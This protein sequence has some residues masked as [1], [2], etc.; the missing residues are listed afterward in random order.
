VIDVDAGGTSEAVLALM[1]PL[2]T[3]LVGGPTPSAT[4]AGPPRPKM[5]KKVARGMIIGGSALFGITYGASTLGAAAVLDGSPN[6]DQF[7]WALSMAVPVV[8]P[9]RAAALPQSKGDR[10]ASIATG[11]MQAGGVALIVGGAVAASRHARADRWDRALGRPVPGSSPNYGKLFA[12]S[13]AVA[14]S[15]YIIT[16]AIG[17]SYVSD[18]NDTPDDFDNPARA[19]AFGRRLTIPLVGGFLAMPK[20]RTHM[21]AWGAGATSM[22]Q[23]GSVATAIVAGVLDRRE[24]QRRRARFSATPTRHGAQVTIAMQF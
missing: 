10:A 16:M 18:V 17:A 23:L 4:P 13:G 20:A 22:I 3:A 11:F 12:T 7:R 2:V 14:L 8:G 19:R 21:G 9:F 6:R 5:E 15:A 24:E 1:L